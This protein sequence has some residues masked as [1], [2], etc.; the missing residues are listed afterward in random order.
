MLAVIFHKIKVGTYRE[1]P[2]QNKWAR[3]VR[4]SLGLTQQ[5]LADTVGV[6][7]EDVDLL[8]RNLPMQLD[9]K[10]KLYIKLHADAAKM[11]SKYQLSFLL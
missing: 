9:I 5:E 11:A 2:S 4:I 1:E 8:E 10:R 7:K 3:S 6:S